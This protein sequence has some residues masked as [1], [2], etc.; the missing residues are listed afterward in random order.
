MGP[1]V[2]ARGARGAARGARGAAG[3]AGGAGRGRGRPGGGGRG[4]ERGGGGAPPP[5]ADGG[6]V[7][8]ESLG[9]DPG[10]EPEPEPGP[11]R[12]A[13]S[14]GALGYG[15]ALADPL[16]DWQMVRLEMAFQEGRRKVKVV[17]LA[18]QLELPREDCLAWLRA[19]PDFSEAEVE[20]LGALMEATY[21]RLQV[22]EKTAQRQEAQAAA[23]PF[24]ERQKGPR[25]AKISAKT[26][27]T[28]ELLWQ[29][30][31]FP[32]ERAVRDASRLCGVSPGVVRRWFK[33]RRE[34]QARER[35]AGE[36]APGSMGSVPRDEEGPGQ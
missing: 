1:A 3:A 19:R 12:G 10:P 31:T 32:G 30:S 8:P 26:R 34:A 35:L 5:W 33:E 7:T 22:L 14:A 15:G 21:E 20:S 23:L 2:G 36:G 11:A 9:L 27:R 28:L 4:G 17:E 29:K 18:E 6:E 13:G 24:R 25:E 16:E